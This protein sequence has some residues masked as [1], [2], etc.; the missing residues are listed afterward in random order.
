MTRTASLCFLVVMFGACGSVESSGGDDAGDDAAQSGADA[1]V[2]DSADGSDGASA[3]DASGDAP[4]AAENMATVPAGPFMMG[5]NAAVDGETWC[6]AP[7]LGLERP[8][9]EVTLD[10]F[11]IDVAEVSE[12][13]YGGCIADG[14]CSAPAEGQLD[15]NSYLPVRNVTWQQAATYC[16]WRSAR[17]P[18]EAEWEKA[19]RGTDGR[20]FP[21]GSAAPDCDR[22]N[23]GQCTDDEVHAVNAHESGASPFGVLNLAGNVAEWVADWYSFDYYAAS[24][25]ENP[26][27]PSIGTERSV[28]G[29]NLISTDKEVRASARRGSNPELGFGNVGFRCA[30]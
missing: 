15:P 24:P 5:C 14:E 8:Y 1:H 4:S 27:G 9:H 17:L 19:A 11:A 6:S 2:S 29:G 10:E 23:Y 21:W 16:A 12:L 20:R 22:V 3:A 13:E 26:T 28:R 25:S 30:R 7:A 18:T